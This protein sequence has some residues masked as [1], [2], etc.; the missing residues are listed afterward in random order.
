MSRQ[1][2]GKKHMNMNLF[3]KPNQDARPITYDLIL[4][5]FF[6]LLGTI[7]RF[8][9]VGLEL[10]PFPNFELIM[11]L[12]FI[13]FLLIRPSL[14]FLIP[15]LSM[16]FSDLLLG[17][18]IFIGSSMNK[19]VLFTYTGF[20]LISFILLKTKNKS[21]HLSKITLKNTGIILGIGMISTLIFDIWT[22]AGWWY[23]MFPHTTEAFA[24]VFIAGIPFMIYH[25]LSTAITFLTIAIPLGYIFTH[26]YQLDLPRQEFN[27]EKIPVIAVTTVLILLSFSGSTMAVPEQTDIWLE[28]SPETSVS[29]TI[30]GSTWELT[31]QVIVTEKTTVLNILYIMTEKNELKMDAEYDE[32]LDATMI[33]SIQKDVNGDNGYYW[34]YTVNGEMPVTGADNTMVSNGDIIIWQFNQ[35]S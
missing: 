2:G 22:N 3:S 32:S 24:S 21:N 17:N 20:L 19:I 16:I 15:L 12:T 18:P 28:N 9:L 30:K 10:Q 8:F 11:V 4:V 33:N 34:Q 29:I 5:S 35:F 31:D 25:Q 23:L 13:S 26:K 14:V 27:F 1:L 6:I 7:S